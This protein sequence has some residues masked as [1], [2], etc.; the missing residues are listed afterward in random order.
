MGQKPS[1][2]RII[3]L[4]VP[5]LIIAMIGDWLELALA[6]VMIF[7]SVAIAALCWEFVDPAWWWIAIPCIA[8][9]IA[10]TAIAIWFVNDPFD[11]LEHHARNR[12]KDDS[13]NTEVHTDR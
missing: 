13:S 9:N 12:E 11:W 5:L 6:F 10:W 1:M 7:G 3:L 4:A 2:L 8:L